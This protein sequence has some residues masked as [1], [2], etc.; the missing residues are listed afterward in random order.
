MSRLLLPSIVLALVLAASPVRAL[1]EPA[2]DPLDE[3]TVWADRPHRVQLGISYPGVLDIR[4]SYAVLPKLRAGASFIGLPPFLFGGALQGDYLLLD[5]R[6]GNKGFL[7]ISGGLQALLV[8]YNFGIV[9]IRPN[10]I[11]WGVG[12]E[13]ALDIGFGWFSAGVGVG[14]LIGDWRS[15]ERDIA[16]DVTPGENLVITFTLPRLAVNW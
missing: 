15:L 3:T 6:L 12:P 9:G 1:E 8:K 2:P 11:D 4:Y 10:D 16:P 5:N 7:T 14:A 13:V